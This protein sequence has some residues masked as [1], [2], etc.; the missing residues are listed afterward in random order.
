MA[1]NAREITVKPHSERGNIEISSE[2]VRHADQAT[3]V[4]SGFTRGSEPRSDSVP[5]QASSEKSKRSETRTRS[6]PPDIPPLH[7]EARS[8]G[9]VPAAGRV[10]TPRRILKYPGPL[11][12]SLSRRLSPLPL[13]SSLA[14]GGGGGE[15]SECPR[16]HGYPR[17]LG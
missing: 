16:I 6:S 11:V 3:S 13:P 1:E 14:P 9:N 17:L 2:S 12:V 15:G 10:R 8:N 5:A 7:R 4:S